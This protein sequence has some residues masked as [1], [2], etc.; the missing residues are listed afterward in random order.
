MIK[1]VYTLI[2]GIQATFGLLM[3]FGDLYAFM[4][5]IL[6]ESVFNLGAFEC[7]D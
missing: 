2:L 6:V 5:A 7:A 4:E 1:L 3:L